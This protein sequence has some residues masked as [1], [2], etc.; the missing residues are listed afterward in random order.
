MAGPSGIEPS[1]CRIGPRQDQPEWTQKWCPGWDLNPHAFGAAPSRRCVYQFHHLG[2]KYSMKY[3][4]EVNLINQMLE[5]IPKR[6]ES[7]KD[8]MLYER[9][10]LTGFLAS[11]AAEDSYI[12]S[13]I[14]ERI[15]ELDKQNRTLKINE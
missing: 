2:I 3:P 13:R 1:T 15:N 9:G 7:V 5:R 6:Y 14:I 8:Q 12:R 11:L 10:Y 4:K